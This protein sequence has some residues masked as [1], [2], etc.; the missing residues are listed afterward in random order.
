MSRLLAPPVGVPTSQF[1]DPGQFAT[2]GLPTLGSY[3]RTVTV[4]AD[5]TS[6]TKG[7]W[8]EVI[9]S[10]TA[11]TTHLL[12]NVYG[13][14]VSATDTR[15]LLDVGVGSSASEVAIVS[16]LPAGFGYATAEYLGHSFLLPLRVAAG[17]RIAARLQAL[18]SADTAIVSIYCLSMP[19]GRRSPSKLV[20]IGA[21]ETAS[22]SST[23]MTASNT[24][25]QVTASTTE[26][27][28]GLIAAQCC[29]SSTNFPTDTA[30][31]L[32]LAAGAAGAEVA[33]ASS[34]P[35]SYVNAEAFQNAAGWMAVAAAS[36]HIPA[37]TR[38]A[39]KITTGRTYKGAIVFGVPYT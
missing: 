9:A 12:V 7:A 13:M 8:S 37:G 32:T 25:A 15:G 38:I 17:S 14:A 4:T 3:G 6:H 18:I 20:T 19:S 11:D 27:F 33:L 35:A 24:Y 26:A 23:F 28:A 30:E 22:T 29:G 2:S 36:R 1:T 16:D 5:A 10:T 34:V 39:C 21:D 31:V